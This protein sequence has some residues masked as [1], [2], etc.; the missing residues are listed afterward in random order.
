MLAC[1]VRVVV[2]GVSHHVEGALG[3]IALQGLRQHQ[4]QR[5]A[6]EV[7]GIGGQTAGAIVKGHGAHP[8]LR[9]HPLNAAHRGEVDRGAR[10]DLILK[11]VLGLFGKADAFGDE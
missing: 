3:A 9:G 5:L 4:G 11:A 6:P 2:G 7:V 8:L 10:P 1:L